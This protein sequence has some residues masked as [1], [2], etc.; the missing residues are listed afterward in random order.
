MDNRSSLVKKLVA[1][2]PPK[3]IDTTTP[4]MTFRQEPIRMSAEAFAHAIDF[5]LPA[6]RTELLALLWTFGEVLAGHM[7]A[8][9]RVFVGDAAPARLA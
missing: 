9:E 5:E 3:A 7:E 4:M 6:D 1:L 2:M 8:R